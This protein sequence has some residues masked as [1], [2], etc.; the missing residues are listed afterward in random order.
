MG[1]GNSMGKLHREGGVG[2]T[3]HHLVKAEEIA[4]RCRTEVGKILLTGQIP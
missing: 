3:G 2:S 4:Q 1:W